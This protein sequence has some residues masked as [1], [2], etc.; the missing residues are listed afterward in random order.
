MRKRNSHGGIIVHSPIT[1]P[2]LRTPTIY[3]NVGDDSFIPQSV[4]YKHGRVSHE[5]V[6][7]I[8]NTFGVTGIPL[9]MVLTHIINTRRGLI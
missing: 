6:V 2:E 1:R 4:S 7:A 8:Y 3:S 5:M 9:S